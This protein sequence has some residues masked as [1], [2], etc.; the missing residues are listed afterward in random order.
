VHG[1]EEL[2]AVPR[3]SESYT[4]QR[5]AVW[6]GSNDHD[7]PTVP[8]PDALF[9]LDICA[10]IDDHMGCPGYSVLRVGALLLGPVECTCTCHKKK[11]TITN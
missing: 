9:K 10:A 6:R 5:G 4:R 8:F 7:T 2:R 3:L 11:R 1:F